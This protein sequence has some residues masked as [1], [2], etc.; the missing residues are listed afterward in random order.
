MAVHHVGGFLETDFRDNL[1]LSIASI[2]GRETGVLPV[3]VLLQSRVDILAN[4]RHSIPSDAVMQW[5]V[6][7]HRNGNR[8]MVI[9]MLSYGSSST[10][11]EI[12]TRR[13]EEHI[14]RSIR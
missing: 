12:L 11:R 8:K 6:E 9:W 4:E 13:S 7:I 10:W 2:Q 14:D 1:Q 5:R 3:G